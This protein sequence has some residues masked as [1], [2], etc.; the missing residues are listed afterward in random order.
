MLR[1]WISSFQGRLYQA[2]SKS[3]LA[4]AAAPLSDA[5]RAWFILFICLRAC[6]IQRL[7]SSRV[8]VS[9]KSHSLRLVEGYSI[10]F[11]GR[12]S[13]TG[14]KA[15]P[16]QVLGIA[17][18]PVRKAKLGSL[19]VRGCQLFN[20]LPVNLRNSDHGD[21]P[22]F[23]NHLDIFLSNIP[24]QPTIPGLSRGTATNSLIDQIP[25]YNLNSLI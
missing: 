17:P 25:I 4:A 19:A 15:Q 16:A 1:A 7:W 12:D 2:V 20:L 6:P 3:C 21:I 8:P 24:D 14:R 11:S 22:M 9:S 13:R 5:R 23:K 10:P 18:G